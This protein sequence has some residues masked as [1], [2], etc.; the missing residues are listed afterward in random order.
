MINQVIKT[1]AQAKKVA[2]AMKKD[3]NS[4]L[5]IYESYSVVMED[6]DSQFDIM[7]E[8]RKGICH[9]LTS[10]CLESIEKV[11]AMYR[12]QYQAI[13]YHLDVDLWNGEYIPA[14]VICVSWSDK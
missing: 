10:S 3:I 9:I 11:L 4:V 8:S 13:S 7:V 6:H 12:T 14:M 5:A 2:N 1:K